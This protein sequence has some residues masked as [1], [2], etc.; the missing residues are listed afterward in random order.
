MLQK[1]KLAI[2]REVYIYLIMLFILALVMH[3]DLLTN[4]VSRFETMYEKGNYSHP[5]LYTFIIY[6][7]LFIIRKI[8]DFI[9]SIFERKK[10]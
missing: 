4:P 9:I 6:S 2:K 7:I 5:F 8:L 3:I 1:F 10:Q